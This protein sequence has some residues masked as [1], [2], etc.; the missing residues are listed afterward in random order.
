MTTNLVHS[1]S[2]NIKIEG[3]GGREES[4]LPAPSLGL[5]GSS[6]AKG[7]PCIPNTERAVISCMWPGRI[8]HSAPRWAKLA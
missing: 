6:R 5:R 1:N 8:K 4:G 7:A 3:R 2:N